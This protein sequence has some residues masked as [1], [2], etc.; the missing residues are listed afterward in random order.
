MVGGRNTLLLSLC[1]GLLVLANSAPPKAAEITCVKAREELNIA[2]QVI[3]ELR[4]E[5]T[6]VYDIV[7]L[8]DSMI[9]AA[10]AQ[11]EEHFGD[12]RHNLGIIYG[13]QRSF[14][15]SFNVMAPVSEIS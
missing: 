10:S 8:V 9:A 11:V 15:R 2:L 3:S 12:R 6:E 1:M 14:F 5:L 7:G 13:C 4:N